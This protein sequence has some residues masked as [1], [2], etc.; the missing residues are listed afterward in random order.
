MAKDVFDGA[1]CVPFTKDEIH[2]LLNISQIDGEYKLSVKMKG[3]HPYFSKNV[4]LKCSK[5]EIL[6]GKSQNGHE[7]E[8]D[9]SCVKDILY[10]YCRVYTELG[11]KIL[12]CNLLYRTFSLYADDF[13]YSPSDIK[14]LLKYRRVVH[15]MLEE[16]I[17]PEFVLIIMTY[18][19]FIICLQWLNN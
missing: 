1:Y 6:A 11:T 4:D 14:N 8:C 2:S 17:M 16:I 9:G 12:H 13:E 5:I 19:N 15:N 10:Y 3:D 7:E 18:Q